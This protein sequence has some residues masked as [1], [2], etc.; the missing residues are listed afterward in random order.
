MRQKK[1]GYGI[2]RGGILGGFL[3]LFLGSSIQAEDCSSL[4][5]LESKTPS[6]QT[7][8]DPLPNFKDSKFLSRWK[9]LTGLS[10]YDKIRYLLERVGQSNNR[11]IRNGVSYDG[12]KARSWLL[13]KWGRWKEDANTAESF[14][15][16][17]TFSRESGK[18]YLVQLATGEVC[19]LKLILRNE[20]SAFETYRAPPAVVSVPIFS[21]KGSQ[22]ETLLTPSPGS[23]SP[24]T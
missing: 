6:S 7:F 13:Y 5:R 23:P 18:P 12:K 24:K 11:F 19:A 21:T 22:S 15:E 10:E 1:G 9:N 2:R 14:I 4:V 8:L 16:K 17:I 3:V 20:L